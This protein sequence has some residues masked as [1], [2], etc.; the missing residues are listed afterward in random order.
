[1]GDQA[2]QRDKKIRPENVD[3]WGFRYRVKK[4]SGS[5]GIL[6]SFER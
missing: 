6:Y 5:S 1:M 3:K 4:L 2:Q